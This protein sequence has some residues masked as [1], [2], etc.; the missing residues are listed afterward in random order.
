MLRSVEITS[1]AATSMVPPYPMTKSLPARRVICHAT[2]SAPCS[3]TKSSTTSAAHLG[4]VGRQARRRHPTAPL[5]PGLG[6][7]HELGELVVAAHQLESGGL[8]VATAP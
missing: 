3:P 1:M 7:H 2:R 4:A 5:L 8:A 6:Q